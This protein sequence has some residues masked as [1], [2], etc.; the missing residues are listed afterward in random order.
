MISEI[1][2]V[3]I[4]IRVPYCKHESNEVENGKGQYNK[5]CT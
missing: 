4:P 5:P 3:T 1:K 2:Y